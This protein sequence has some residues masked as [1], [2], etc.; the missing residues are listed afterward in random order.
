MNFLK[1]LLIISSCSLSFFRAN[2]GIPEI[3][4][5][6]GS[7]NVEVLSKYLDSNV[8]FCLN[9]NQQTLSK[10]Q[11]I[12]QLKKFFSEN[13]P[14]SFKQIHKGATKNKDSVYIIGSLTTSTGNYRIYVYMHGADDK[15]TVQEIRLNKE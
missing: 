12:T 13:T 5:A 6:L 1:L 2:A 14:K 10:Q 9:D 8:E 4:N 11:A 15:T 7:G 3:T